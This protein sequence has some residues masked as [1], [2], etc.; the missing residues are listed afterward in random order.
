MSAGPAW[1]TRPALVA[2]AFLIV[3]ASALMLEG[4]FDRAD[5]RKARSLVQ[6]SYVVNGVA[7]GDYLTR[8]KH[9]NVEGAYWDTDVK[10]GCASIVAVSYHVPM[11][12]GDD[13]VYRF[14]V[15]VKTRGIHPDNELGKQVML[16]WEAW[17]KKQPPP[18]AKP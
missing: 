8:V 7:I 4:F 14:V 5:R 13:L 18:A 12:R 2:I 15:E 17:A 6:H 3:A 16:E 11:A 10:S 9:P 1:Q